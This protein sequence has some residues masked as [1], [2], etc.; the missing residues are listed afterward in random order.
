MVATLPGYYDSMR[1]ALIFIS[2]LATAGQ[3]ST[4]LGDQYPYTISAITTD[5]LGNT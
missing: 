2:T 1:L 5:A 3:F 4:S